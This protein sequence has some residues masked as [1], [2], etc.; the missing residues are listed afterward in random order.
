MRRFDTLIV[1]RLLRTEDDNYLHN[2][3]LR[4]NKSEARVILLYAT[5][6]VWLSFL[7]SWTAVPSLTT[8]ATMRCQSTL[9]SDAPMSSVGLKLSFHRALELCRYL[10]LLRPSL[11]SP[12]FILS[13]TT[14]FLRPCFFMTW[15]WKACCRWRI[16]FITVCCS[17]ADFDTSKVLFVSVQNVGK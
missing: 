10:G 11:S 15:P 17:R 1:L 6:Y 14:K 7:L 4:L 9:S 5:Q 12:P 2:E 8:L 16:L 13:V 3:L